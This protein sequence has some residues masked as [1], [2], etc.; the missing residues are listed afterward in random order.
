MSSARERGVTAHRLVTV[1]PEERRRIERL[2]TEVR[3]ALGMIEPSRHAWN[4]TRLL[5]DFMFPAARARLL[6]AVGCDIERGVGV[7]GHVEIIGPTGCA[8]NLHIGTGS[9]VGPGA[10]FC[11][12]APITIG[13]GVSIGPRA[14]LYTASHAVGKSSRRM[15]PEVVAAPIV[16]EDGAWI[17]L[18][19]TILAGV[20]IGRGA[21]VRAGA[22]VVS[23]V[24]DNAI[25][26]GNPATITGELPDR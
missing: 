13:Q 19:A 5:P 14:L 2:V 24:P 26:A 7:L 3:G 9:V 18:G 15:H 23:D 8:K 21:V 25:V 12:D 10:T 22:V 17:A 16:I 20:R 11:L 6:S 1:E 4:A